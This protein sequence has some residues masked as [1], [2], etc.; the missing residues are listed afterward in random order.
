MTALI[1][2]SDESYQGKTVLIVGNSNSAGDVATEVARSAQKVLISRVCSALSRM[3]KRMLIC[4]SV[5]SN[6]SKS[7]VKLLERLARF[8]LKCG[9][10]MK[11]GLILASK[12]PRNAHHSPI[13]RVPA[14]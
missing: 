1:H 10:T 4:E 14:K 9:G 7:S 8:G 11:C 6:I 3:I 12:S 5:S 13:R 2:F